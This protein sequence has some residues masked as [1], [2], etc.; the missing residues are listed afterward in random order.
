M[1]D[2]TALGGLSRLY[3]EATSSGTRG[4]VIT[5]SASTNTK[6][7]WV[8]LVSSTTSISSGLIVYVRQ[9]NG[10]IL[11]SGL[12]VD[13]GIGAAASE[14]VLIESLKINNGQQSGDSIYGWY[15]PI[16]VSE[17]ERLSARVQSNEASMNAS[18]YIIQVNGSFRTQSMAAKVIA[19]GDN[20]GTTNGT[21]IDPGA[22]NNTKGSWVE[23]SSSTST[24]LYGFNFSLGTDNNAATGGTVGFFVDI[25]VGGSG[26]EAVIAG[27][28]G[29][30]I[31][32]R[33]QSA[34]QSFYCD[35]PIPAG[36]RIAVRGQSSSNNATQRIFDI[37]IHG[38]M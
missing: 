13:I 31:N 27:D 21:T 38:V 16:S 30:C 22:S 24:D 29:M 17:G 1:G 11:G 6:S 37:I 26:S 7:S 19:L 23:I 35:V 32:N 20:T 9:V 2:F 18:V 33:E 36:S 8:E 4:T 14:V 25:A 15:F 5:G 28:I 34:Y 12:M 10:S 3:S